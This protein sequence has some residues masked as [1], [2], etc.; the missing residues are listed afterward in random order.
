MNSTML[1]LQEKSQ[2]RIGLMKLD[3][4]LNIKGGCKMLQFHKTVWNAYWYPGQCEYQHPAESGLFE[5][6]GPETF[7]APGT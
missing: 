7:T 1:Q 3:H 5:S 2:P 6:D 4:G